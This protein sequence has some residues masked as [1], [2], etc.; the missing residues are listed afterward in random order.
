MHAFVQA[1]VDIL[2]IVMAAILFLFT[3][4]LVILHIIT[5]SNNKRIERIKKRIMRMLS[6]AQD[7]E[8]IREQ[9]HQL[10]DATGEVRALRDIS[11]IRSSRGTIA[12]TIVVEESD[13]AQ[14]EL[15]RQIIMHD[16]WY[17]G[18]IRKNLKSN[19]CDRVGVFTKLIAELKLPG[20]ENEVFA[21]LHRFQNHAEN[22]EI[23]LLALFMCGNHDQLVAL[24]SD[25]NIPLILSFRSL[26]E[27]FACYSGDHAALYRELLAR[28]CDSYVIR[29]CIHG[30]GEDE[31]VELCPLIVSY[32]DSDN[33]NLVINSIRTLGKLGYRPATEAIRAHTSHP[34]WSVRSTAVT[35]LAQLDPENCYDELL[36]CL[37]DREWWVRF[38]A[39]EA[40]DGLPGHPNPMSDVEALGDRFA[41]EMMRFIRERREILSQEVAA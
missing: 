11:G 6:V 28:D 12:M 26:Q 32:L 18:H 34:Q 38:H 10:M 31:A 13:E 30:I 29:A 23:G 39:A 36:R 1:A 40:I 8:Y 41:F 37:C 20:Y 25:P 33:T 5:T 14:K 15:L 24:L 27:L 7:L 3:I 2:I 21:N 19:N 22:Q 17:Q 4:G 16:D 9:I 35:A